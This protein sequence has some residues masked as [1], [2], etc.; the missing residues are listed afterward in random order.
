MN[1]YVVG[2]SL[3][4]GSFA[5]AL[6]IGSL[7]NAQTATPGAGAQNPTLL[8]EFVV[9]ATRT[10]EPAERVSSAYTKLDGAEL[11][12]SQIKDVKTAVDLSPGVFSRESGAEGSLTGIS[13]RGNR[14]TDTLVLVDGVRAGS[15]LLTGAAPLLTFAS[16]FNLDDVEII[17]GAHSSLFGSDAIGGVVALQTLRG[18]GKPK[19][20]TTFEGGSFNTFRESIESDGSLGALDYSFHYGR[21]DSSNDRRNNDVSINSASLRLDWTVN[22]KLTIGA[23]MRSQTGTYQEP[24]SIRLVD[25]DNNDTNAEAYSEATV[26]SLYAELRATEWWTSKLTLGMYKERYHFNNP[27]DPLSDHSMIVYPTWDSSAKNFTYYGPYPATP[28]SSTDLAES[29]NWSADLQNTFQITERNKLVLGTTLIYQTGHDE[30][31]YLTPYYSSAATAYQSETNIGTYLEDQWEVIDHLTLSAGLRYDHYELAGDAV[32]YRTGAAYLVEKTRTKLRASYGTAFKEPTFYQSYNTTL[33]T[34]QNL[35]P[36]RSHSWD[37]GLDQYLFKDKIALGVTY[38]HSNTNDLIAYISPNYN[39]PYYANRDALNT[40]GI[41]AAATAQVNAHWQCRVAF[42]WTES[43]ESASYWTDSAQNT[44]SGLQ[45]TPRVPRYI[46]NAD[47]HYTFDLPIGKLT[48]G[49]GIQFVTQREDVDYALFR[50]LTHGAKTIYAAKQAN[51]PDYTVLRFYARYD[52]TEN[53]ALTARVENAAN[54]YYEP[55]LGLPALGRA[56]YGGVQIRF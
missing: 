29:S 51:M 14:N 31:T 5:A 22:Q 27:F 11:E 46:F 13:I 19:V 15:T 49:S 55:S 3:L 54:Q 8:D 36:E 32:T 48:L 56:F 26:L 1:R 42:T 30:S 10:E 45:R 41:E 2:R 50:P 6:C 53:I 20:I 35:D 25:D 33:Y 38:F 28:E 16:T 34:G 44:I 18:S 52:I 12:L 43:E 23:T 37:A 9:T 39:T 21:E 7:A 40:H 4:T 47:T 24:G 17:R